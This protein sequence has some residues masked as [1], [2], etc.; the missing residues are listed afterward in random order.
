ML[1]EYDSGTRGILI[2]PYIGAKVFLT[3]CSSVFQFAPT[4]VK[5]FKAEYITENS[6]KKNKKQVVA[7]E[8]SIKGAC[9]KRMI[10]YGIIPDNCRF[11][12]SQVHDV[13]DSSIYNVARKN[14][15]ENL[16]A[17]RCIL[18]S[19]EGKIFGADVVDY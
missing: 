10:D 5:L 19:E 8:I 3:S 1:Q 2:S 4:R 18:E 13:V 11:F 14:I 15:M 17:K 9:Q 6:E 12:I 7:F 16:G